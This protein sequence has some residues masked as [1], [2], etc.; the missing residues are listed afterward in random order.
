MRLN[1]ILLDVVEIDA[2]YIGKN[3]KEWDKVYSEIKQMINRDFPDAIEWD[4]EVM[5][6]FRRGYCMDAE[7]HV[8]EEIKELYLRCKKY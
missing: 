8:S 2:K 6:S 1:E 7:K 5:P 4:N 3:C